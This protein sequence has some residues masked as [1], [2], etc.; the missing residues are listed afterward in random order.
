ML[1]RLFI[2]HK[3]IFSW[4]NMEFSRFP[5]LRVGVA[6][7]VLGTALIV[8]GKANAYPPSEAPISQNSG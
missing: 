1:S 7:F 4:I 6:A 2:S 8:P 5:Y 3:H